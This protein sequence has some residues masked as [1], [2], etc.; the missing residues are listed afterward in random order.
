[1]IFII[2]HFQTTVYDALSI[3]PPILSDTVRLSTLTI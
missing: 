1:M 2:I 3:S